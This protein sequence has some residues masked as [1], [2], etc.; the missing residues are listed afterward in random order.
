M[1]MDLPL[2]AVKDVTGYRLP[3]AQRVV[4]RPQVSVIVYD[5]KCTFKSSE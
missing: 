2:W 1:L 5:I 3:R 4:E